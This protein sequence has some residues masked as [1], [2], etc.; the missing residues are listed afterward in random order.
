MPNDPSTQT[1]GACRRRPARGEVARGLLAAR[2]QRREA[3]QLARLHPASGLRGAACRRCARGSAPSL[4]G[5][6]RGTCAFDGIDP[7]LIVL[8]QRSGAGQILIA[9]R[10]VATFAVCGVSITL[11]AV[12]LEVVL[13]VN[14]SPD[15][16]VL[17]KTGSKGSLDWTVGVRGDSK[18]VYSSSSDVFDA[19]NDRRDLGSIDDI[20]SWS[21]A[22]TPAT[23]RESEA[24]LRRYEEAR[25]FPFICLIA[26]QTQ[27]GGESIWRTEWG[28]EFGAPVRPMTP[29]QLF[30]VRPIWAGFLLNT[31]FHSGMAFALSLG[32]RRARA[33]VRA[34]RG[35]CRACGHPLAGLARCPECGQA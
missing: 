1:E 4:R 31:C 27:T 12:L 28:I 21:R 5:G 24:F 15:Y 17:V 9:M 3:A 34:R 11:L 13:C 20:P 32:F 30:P 23:R 2:V 29:R 33:V 8:D 25:G 18:A 26:S 10:D 19:R 16:G 7:T 6:K 35:A 14:P 22:R